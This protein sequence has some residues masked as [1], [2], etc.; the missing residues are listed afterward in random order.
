MRKLS[1]SQSLQ[2]SCYF[3]WFKLINFSKH[4]TLF[5]VEFNGKLLEKLSKKIVMLCRPFTLP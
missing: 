3:T 5:E 1:P 4:L 2:L